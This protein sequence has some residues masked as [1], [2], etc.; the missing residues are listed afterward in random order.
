MT[1]LLSP[2]RSN[3]WS[4]CYTVRPVAGTWW[5]YK[6]TALAL[7]ALVL[8]AC[9]ETT[10]KNDPVVDSGGDPGGP[11]TTSDAHSGGGAPT[12]TGVGASGGSGGT[13]SGGSGG[14]G[15]L[16]EAGGAGGE[17]S[18]DLPVPEPTED[19][20]LAFVE[21]L[22]GL[23]T[24]LAEA[25]CDYHV[26][27]DYGFAT[28]FAKVPGGCVG[29]Y[30]REL[31][32]YVAAVVASVE[33]GHVDYDPEAIDVCL[34]DIFAA[35]CETE[36]DFL[37]RGALDGQVAAGDACESSF[38]CQG[39]ASCEAT[40]RCP[41][42]CQV[43]NEPNPTEEP[44]GDT[45]Q[46]E[47]MLC[48]G[49]NG[50]CLPG[51]VCLYQQIYTNPGEPVFTTSQCVRPLEENELCPQVNG[52]VYPCVD[53]LTCAEDVDGMVRCLPR[54]GEGEP[55]SDRSPRC[56]PELTCLPVDDESSECSTF[57]Y[58]ELGDVCDNGFVCAP[59][60]ACVRV[61]DSDSPYRCVEPVSSGGD[62]QGWGTD[63]CPMGEFCPLTPSDFEA[64]VFTATCQPHKGLGEPCS[65]SWECSTFSFCSACGVC[66]PTVAAGA[67]CRENWGCWSN[68]CIDGTCAPLGVPVACL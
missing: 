30:E 47:G 6:R 25:V 50:E 40:D 36:V 48:G 23:A 31:T 4:P 14:G 7:L 68:R 35:E 53:D 9:G 1:R 63:N 33:A 49:N 65:D 54:R 42:V 28:P 29:R 41:G 2:T 19:E 3:S 16:N 27:C 34:A 22:D 12:T 60:L 45:T 21:A 8:E 66:E 58:A 52:A 17:D 10:S 57:R 64:G 15:A 44:P 38:A 55:C 32:D 37:C 11:E 56:E 51:L 5:R 26:R 20:D 13:T 67:P 62:C 24:R 43:L 61:D 46:N 39:D 59:G 18:C